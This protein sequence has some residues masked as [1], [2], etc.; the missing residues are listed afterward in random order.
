VNFQLSFPKKRGEYVIFSLPQTNHY[1][2]IENLTIRGAA[3][4]LRGRKWGNKIALFTLNDV[5][6][7]IEIVFQ[8]S[9]KPTKKTIDDVWSLTDYKNNQLYHGRVV[10]GNDPKI[11]K[12][13]KEVVGEEQNL[14]QVINKLYNFTLGYLTYGRPT[15]GL[16]TYKEALKERITDCGGFSTFLASLLQSLGIPSRLV[17][18]FFI[19]DSLIKIFF[20]NMLH[21]TSYKLQDLLMHAWLEVL[22]PNN[23]WFPLDPSIEWRRNKGLTKRLGG[24]GFI[25]ADRLVVSHGCDFRLKIND[26]IYKVDLLQKP[27]YLYSNDKR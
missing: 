19:K 24:F 17:V 14:R 16:Y 23:S 7:K 20:S 27:V 9:P 13:A 12:I 21:V 11:I 1:Q 5:K 4:I 25:P 6:E 26:K 3:K 8:H 2:T 15:E 22:L 18:G 10:N